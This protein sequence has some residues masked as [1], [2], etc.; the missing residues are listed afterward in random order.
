[1]LKRESVYLQFQYSK[2]QSFKYLDIYSHLPL[3]LITFIEWNLT[4]NEK[5]VKMPILKLDQMKLIRIFAQLGKS[6]WDSLYF[7]LIAF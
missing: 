2:L 4:I 1:M 7:Y 6:W 5:M 3:L